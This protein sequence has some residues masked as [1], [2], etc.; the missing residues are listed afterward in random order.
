MGKKYM[1]AFWASEV[2]ISSG[3]GDLLLVGVEI[4]QEGF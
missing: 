1:G 4:N 2:D 3:F